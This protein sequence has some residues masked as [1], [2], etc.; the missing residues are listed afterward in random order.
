MEHPRIIICRH[1]ESIE[2]V[3]DDIYDILSD[4]EIPLTEP[5]TDQGLKL[6]DTKSESY[7]IH[8]LPVKVPQA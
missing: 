2:D 8:F 3:N 5:R 6:I 7:G 4:L 1:A